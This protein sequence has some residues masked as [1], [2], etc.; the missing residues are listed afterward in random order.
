M[1]ITEGWTIAA[2]FITRMMAL[3]IRSICLLLLGA[4][5]GAWIVHRTESPQVQEQHDFVVSLN[6]QFQEQS[7]KVV[8]L[9]E[10]L[11]VCLVNRVEDLAKAK[12]AR[13]NLPD[14]PS[15]PSSPGK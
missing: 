13:V 12:A 7:G 6:K 10:R 4:L 15:S 1:T 5:A 3:T 11:R 9:G 8:E 14:M 2:D